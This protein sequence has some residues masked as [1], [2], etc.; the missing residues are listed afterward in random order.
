MSETYYVSWF[1][2]CSVHYLSGRLTLVGLRD[3]M[4]VRRIEGEGVCLSL[5]TALDMRWSPFFQAVM[6][7]FS[8]EGYRLN[9]F[10]LREHRREGQSGFVQLRLHYGRPE[11]NVIFIAPALDRGGSANMW[12]RLL[13]KIPCWAAENEI[14]RVYATLPADSPEE[15]IFHRA[16]FV[17]YTTDTVY[18]LDSTSDFQLAFSRWQ[19]ERRKSHE[20]PIE[21]T[22]LREQRPRDTWGLKNLYSAVTP[23]GVQQAEGLINH[24]WHVPSDDWCGHAWSRSF[25]CEGPD[26]LQAH[27]GLRRGRHGHW[28]RVITRPEQPELQ[29]ALLVH[30][31]E[32]IAEWPE[33][34][35]YCTVRSYQNGL[36]SMLEELGFA[37]VMDRA[38]TVRHLVLSVRPALEEVI[39]R[40]NSV[41]GAGYNSPTTIG[42]NGYSCKGIVTLGVPTKLAD[43]QRRYDE[44]SSN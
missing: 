35:V 27:L 10:V 6:S 22:Q 3:L 14:M 31:M 30:A 8:F 44:V 15:G 37:P 19:S 38:L 18:R 21:N 29:L 42:D 32:T 20:M 40:V 2:G 33:K 36:G 9:T 16:G 7:L 1:A 24:G 13:G 39:Q 34:P 25:V 17:R 41:V 28:F 26:G 4:T 23:L 43:E 11:A 12:E 5:E